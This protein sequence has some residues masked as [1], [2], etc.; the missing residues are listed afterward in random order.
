MKFFRKFNEIDKN[1]IYTD[2]H[3]HTNWTD[4]EATV[5]EM[6]KKAEQIGLTQIAFTEHVR[7]DS[8]YFDAYLKEVHGAA[9]KSSIEILFG[10]EAKIVGLEGHMDVPH[11]SLEKS[12]IRIASVFII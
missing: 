3:I 11:G 2:K 8:T 4:G 10:L 1:Y 6:V 12:D 5:L 9:E 7:S